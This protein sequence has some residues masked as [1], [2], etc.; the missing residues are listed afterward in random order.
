MRDQDTSLMV[1]TFLN[2][3]DFFY[4]LKDRRI[5]FHNVRQTNFFDFNNLSNFGEILA[6]LDPMVW[7]QFFCSLASWM[8]SIPWNSK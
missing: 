1:H 8:L 2:F 6:V 3:Y 7:K 5:K 4:K